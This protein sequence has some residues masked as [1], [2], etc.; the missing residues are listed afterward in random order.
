QQI[1]AAKKFEEFVDLQN[2]G[3]KNDNGWFKIVYTPGQA[4]D[5]IA[6]GRLAVV[7][8]G[9]TAELLNCKFPIEQCTIEEHPP[10]VGPGL[11]FPLEGRKISC[12]ATDSYAASGPLTV[13]WLGS[14]GDSLTL[15]QTCTPEYVKQRVQSLYDQ[16]IRHV[17]PI[18]NFDNAFG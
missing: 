2:D 5:A 8:G 12:P 17:F 15:F 7:V 16:G 1:W 3:V 9:E 11:N 4:R 14:S 10:I 6:H 13:P 18:H